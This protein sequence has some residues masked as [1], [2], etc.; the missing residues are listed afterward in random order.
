MKLIEAF[1]YMKKI[2]NNG[3]KNDFSV[4]NVRKGVTKYIDT[5]VEQKA[6]SFNDRKFLIEV[7][8]KIKPIMEDK[9]TADEAFV[10]VL[11]ATEKVDYVSCSIDDSDTEEISHKKESDVI[12]KSS[13]NNSNEEPKTEVI[14][15]RE[16]EH[17]P[18]D[19]MPV[20]PGTCGRFWEYQ[21]KARWEEK[22]KRDP[23]PNGG[24]GRFWS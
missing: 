6:I 8:K 3:K 14:K 22:W 20:D 17:H 24:C 12:V 9:I 21:K 1:N 18:W 15:T 4:K 19:N 16:V 7:S 10:E 2:I 13:K 5:L 23:E 11:S